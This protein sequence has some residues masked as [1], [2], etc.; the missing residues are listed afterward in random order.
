MILIKHL[1]EVHSHRCIKAT[2]SNTYIAKSYKP[3]H[4][5]KLAKEYACPNARWNIVEDRKLKPDDILHY[6][7]IIVA[8]TKTDRIMKEMDKVD[9]IWDCN[10]PHLSNS[11]MF[12]PRQMCEWY[13]FYKNIEENDEVTFD[14]EEIKKD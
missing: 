5:P 10:P 6:Q 13:K 4:K 11:R 2:I 14:L 12:L 8:L 3:T 7:K 9:I 1:K